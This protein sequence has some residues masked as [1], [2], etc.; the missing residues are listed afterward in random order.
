MSLQPMSAQRPLMP[1]Q[2]PTSQAA[3][4]EAVGASVFDTLCFLAQSFDV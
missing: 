4:T 3:A 1:I 2:R